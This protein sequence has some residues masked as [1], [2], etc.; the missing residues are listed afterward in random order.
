MI[1]DWVLNELIQECVTAIGIKEARNYCSIAIAEGITNPPWIGRIRSTKRM[2]IHSVLDETM[3]P[4]DLDQMYEAIEYVI[5]YVKNQMQLLVDESEAEAMLQ[6]ARELCQ[7]KWSD[8][9]S[10]VLG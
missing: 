6:V 9:L 4:T 7:R 2:K 1:N 5:Q 10:N 8:F 3:T